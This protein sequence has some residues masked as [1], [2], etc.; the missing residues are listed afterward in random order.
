MTEDFTCTSCKQTGP[1]HHACQVPVK[2]KKMMLADI[3]ALAYF[4]I[5]CGR[6]AREKDVLCQ[7]V[8][9]NEKDKERFVRAGITTSEAD[10]CSV[11][12][13]PTSPPGHVCDP[14]GLPYTCEYCGEVVKSYRHMCKQIVD[15]ARYT[16]KNCGRIAV[17]KE[18][19]CAPIKLE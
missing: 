18:H 13:Q 17:K 4:C 16:C 9:L 19:L 7:P 2:D 14:K 3:K 6:V 10:T 11:C 15:Q 12:G 8:A 5:N 1:H